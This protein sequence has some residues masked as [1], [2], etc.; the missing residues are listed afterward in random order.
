MIGILD[1]VEK[2][3]T[4]SVR[5]SKHLFKKFDAWGID[6]EFFRKVLLPQN[7]RVVVHDTDNDKTYSAVS[8]TI[9]KKGNWFHFKSDEADHL[10]QIFLSRTYWN[11]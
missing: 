7:Y 11:Q 9:D 10:A 1:D 2:T 3:F 4:K 8:E 6:G 5:E